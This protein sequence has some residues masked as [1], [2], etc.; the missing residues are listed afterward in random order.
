VYEDFYALDTEDAIKWARGLIG[1]P[2]DSR[3]VVG[4]VM[5]CVAGDVYAIRNPDGRG[6]YRYDNGP[7]LAPREYRRAWINSE[8]NH[9]EME[10]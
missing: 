8:W 10:E 5:K 1:K 6:Y 9:I 2:D 7:P 3:L 4:A